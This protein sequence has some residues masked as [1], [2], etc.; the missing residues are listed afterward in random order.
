V[1]FHNV[2]SK[3]AYSGL[4]KRTYPDP[5]ELVEIIKVKSENL[6]MYL[7]LT[8]HLIKVDVEGAELLVFKGAVQTLKTHKPY[9]L[10]EHGRGAADHYGTTPNM[11]YEYLY[12]SV[13]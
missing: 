9:I 12:M 10:F 7:S 13:V 3:P 6:T 5:S 2:V 8:V 1:D 11:M 4:Q